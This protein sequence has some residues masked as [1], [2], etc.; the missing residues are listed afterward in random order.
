VLCI[1]TACDV[2]RTK[3]TLHVQTSGAAL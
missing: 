1:F 2:A 3:R